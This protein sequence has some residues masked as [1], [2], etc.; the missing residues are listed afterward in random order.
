L[1]QNAFLNVFPFFVHDGEVEPKTDDASYREKGPPASGWGYQVHSD[2]NRARAYGPERDP[3]EKQAAEF[4]I[5]RQK[6]K[7]V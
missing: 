1:P 2:A 3:S 4:L 6:G 7:T 5:G